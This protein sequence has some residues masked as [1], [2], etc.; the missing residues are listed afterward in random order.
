MEN[1]KDRAE[2]HRLRCNTAQQR[3]THPEH[4]CDPL[5]GVRTFVRDRSLSHTSVPASVYPQEMMSPLFI[6]KTINIISEQQGL[7]WSSIL[8][9]SESYF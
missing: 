5:S 6:P 9:H 2:L 4:A 8:G 1:G 7:K 3:R